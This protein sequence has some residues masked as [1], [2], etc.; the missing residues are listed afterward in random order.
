MG[1]REQDE[2]CTRSA[3]ALCSAITS[4]F[5]CVGANLCRI[6]ADKRTLLPAQR[7]HFASSSRAARH[8]KRQR[9]NSASSGIVVGTCVASGVCAP[10][11]YRVANGASS[12]SLA[13]CGKRVAAWTYSLFALRSSVSPCVRHMR[14]RHF[15][16]HASCT[17]EAARQ[18]MNV[19]NARNG[20]LWRR[21][22]RKRRRA[23]T[24]WATAAVGL[25]TGERARSGEISG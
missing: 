5:C 7:L 19:K 23:K 1:L 18:N 14:V 9:M 20:A 10:R 24:A 16:C 12:T 17:S 3:S 13:R 25:A 8:Q 2:G 21:A 22:W 15:L 11:R 4:A 6:C